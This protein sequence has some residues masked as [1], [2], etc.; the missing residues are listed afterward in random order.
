MEFSFCCCDSERAR[1]AVKI[2]WVNES[3][4]SK[5]VT[6]AHDHSIFAPFYIMQ[7]FVPC[8]PD[9]T[10]AVV[11]G[12]QTHRFSKLQP[13]KGTVTRHIHG[14]VRR[15]QRSYFLPISEA[16]TFARGLTDLVCTYIVPASRH[17]IKP[18]HVC[19]DSWSS[20]LFRLHVT[21]C[22]LQ[23]ALSRIMRHTRASKGTAETLSR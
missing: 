12:I 20:A 7:R 19:D 21:S 4:Y 1:N 14:V 5:F 15:Q 10:F 23:M 17:Y 11:V 3:E 2:S 8:W 22:Q 18:L 9:T 16:M 13:V 6:S